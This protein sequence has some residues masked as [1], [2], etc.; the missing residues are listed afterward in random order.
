MLVKCT[1]PRCAL[2]LLATVFIVRAGQAQE[3][4]KSRNNVAVGYKDTPILPWIQYH[5]HDPYL[6]RPARRLS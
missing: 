4:I 5:K 1:S 2:V 3:L 6:R